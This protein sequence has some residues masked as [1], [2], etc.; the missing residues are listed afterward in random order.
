MSIRSL[1]TLNPYFWKY[2]YRL[3]SGMVFILIGNFFKVYPSDWVKQA[4]NLIESTAKSYQISPQAVAVDSFYHDL[5]TYGMY[6]LGATLM[7][8]I[9]TFFMRQTIVVMSRHIEYDL[10]NAMYAHY[11]K[12]DQYFYKQNRTGDLMARLSEDIGAVRMYAGPAIM[13]VLTSI[14]LFIIVI[15]KMFQTDT[16]MTWYALAPLPILSIVIYKLSSLD[17]EYYDEYQK[18][19][20]N[21]T[22]YTQE[23]FA[24]I[25][26]TRA[27][28]RHESSNTHFKIILT[29]LKNKAFQLMKVDSLYNPSSS[30]LTGLSTI[31][32]VWVAAKQGVPSGTITEFVFFLNLLIW[33][34]ISLGWTSTMIQ[35]AAVSQRRINE[36]LDQQPTITS[37]IT[38]TDEAIKGNIVFK[39]VSFQYDAIRKPALQNISFDIPAG[40]SIGIMGRTGSG[41][42]TLATLIARFYDVTSGEILIDGKPIKEIP[43]TQLRT[44]I[45]YVP[46]EVFL[47]SE[48]IANNVAFG[49]R[50]EYSPENLRKMVIQATDNA[51]ITDN[52][53]AFQE[54][55]ETQ[56]GERGV[57]LSGGQKQRISIARALAELPNILLLDDCL[58]AVDTETEEIILQNMKKLMLHKTTIM[59]SHRVSTI[60]N[61]DRIIVLENGRIIEQGTHDE[62][63]NADGYYA[64]IYKHQLK[65]VEEVIS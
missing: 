36:F 62:L 18:E 59:V 51:Y 53:E 6:I 5:F 28:N 7:S 14:T 44:Q 9:C 25:R 63:A 42:S 56:I 30:F 37:P 48:T 20:S 33:P 15:V 50:K 39:D 45:G 58:S 24:G 10:R 31:L 13:Y 61:C 23:T 35:R 19:V 32:V 49:I 4:V 3:L 1:A 46:Q 12:L 26:V 8:A 21:I 64:T 22:S 34:V 40:T 29:N 11:Q 55:F 27:Y 54:G 38:T 2:K 52:V 41:K 43:L 57:S 47:F 60:K 65:Q 17:Y 16:M